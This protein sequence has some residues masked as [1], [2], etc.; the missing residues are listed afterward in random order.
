MTSK[1]LEN[2]QTELMRVNVFTPGNP[3]SCGL[4]KRTWEHPG[5]EQ[6]AGMQAACCSAPLTTS[7][8]VTTT[9]NLGFFLMAQRRGLRVG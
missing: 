4:Q 1:D 8:T 5:L 7:A 6:E 3:K 9:T 2:P